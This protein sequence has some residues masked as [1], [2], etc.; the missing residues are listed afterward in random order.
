[1][2]NLI[3]YSNNHSKTSGILLQYY[4]DKPALNNAGALADFPGNSTS[5]KFKQKI[6]GSTGNDGTTNVEIM[7]PLAQ[8]FR[9]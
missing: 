1:M 5:F 2:Y 8:V 4:R 7:V 3:E 6:T 9:E